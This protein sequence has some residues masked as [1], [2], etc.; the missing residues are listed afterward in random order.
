MVKAM[1]IDSQE[2]TRISWA[3]LLLIHLLH[4]YYYATGDMKKCY[5][6]PGC[7]KPWGIFPDLN[8]TISNMG[9]IRKPSIIMYCLH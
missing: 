9:Y 3:Y 2:G 4:L 6:N 1:E 7:A 8:H 5:L